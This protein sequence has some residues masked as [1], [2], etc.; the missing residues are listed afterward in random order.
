MPVGDVSEKVGLERFLAQCVRELVEKTAAHRATWHLGDEAS[1]SVD[2][3]R[4]EICF[5]FK[6]VTARAPVQIIGTFNTEDSTFLWGWDHPSVKAPLRKHA[7]CLRRWGES[8]A[9]ARL[10]TRSFQS[11]EEEAWAFAAAAASVNDANGAYRGR[12]GP[13]WVYMTF[14]QVSLSVAAGR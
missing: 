4:E 1:W 5:R 7:E 13:T 10:V 11:S 8:H 6:D 2:Q 3:D 12:S 9:E 14:G